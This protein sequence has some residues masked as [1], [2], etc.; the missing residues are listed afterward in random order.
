MISNTN[1][2]ALKT[3]PG[4][5][6]AATCGACGSGGIA[7]RDFVTGLGVAAGL[8][9]TGAAA[10]QSGEPARQMPI[11]T[12]LIIQP[13]FLYSTPTRRQETSWRSWGA[14]QT[15]E[16]A[17]AEKNRIQGELAQMKKVAEFPLE[18]LPLAPVKTRDDAAALAKGAYDMTLNFT[19][20]YEDAVMDTLIAPPEHHNLMFVR[21][22]SGPVYLSYEHAH[23]RYVRKQVDEK[24]P[25][26]TSDDVVV[27]SYAEVLWRLR[28]LYG[29]KNTL[30]KRIV[31]VGGEGG[32]GAGGRGASNRA[33][34][35]WKFDIQNVSYPELGERVKRAHA[36]DTLVKRCLAAADSYLKDK[37]VTSLETSREAVENCFVLTEVFHDLLDEFHTDSIT[38]NQCMGTIM[39]VTGTTACIPLSI[40][41]SDGYQAFCE[42]DFVV[43]PAGTL[44]SY[45]ASKPFFM[46]DPTYPHDGV[47]TCAH[48]TA[49]RKLDGVQVDPVRIRTH[50][51]SDF[52]AAPKVEFRKG[53]AVTNVV[54]DF[55]GKRWLGVA[56]E[57]LGSPDMPICR[58]QVDIGIKGDTR[59]LV[60]EIRGF[61]W[62]T[63]YGDYL[64]E[65]G[66]AVKK[67]NTDWLTV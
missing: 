3:G 11:R 22:R 25:G 42:S 13:V 29:L 41:N 62:M 4:C 65:V 63:A 60:E 19:A 55:A 21:H 45:I 50:F 57:V 31:T 52:G 9:L 36:N 23:P 48:C 30:G 37:K 43:I 16:D 44:L 1:Q 61:H 10:A 17:S 15:E 46:S 7:R 38:I 54:A 6:G 12:P 67:N 53:Q 8:A 34:E 33:R 28:A 64:R 59:K 2:A 58:S 24:Y 5:C 35:T 51:E 40:L 18:I 26:R 20:G 47:V 66:Y 27:D 49:P 14:I 32:W 56:G 39:Q